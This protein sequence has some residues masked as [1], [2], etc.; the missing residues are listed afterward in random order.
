LE[1]DTEDDDTVSVVLPFNAEEE[2]VTGGEAIMV[3]VLRW[4]LSWLLSC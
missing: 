4:L 2:V 3:Y 1:D